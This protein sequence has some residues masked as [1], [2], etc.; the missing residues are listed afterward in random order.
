MIHE[1]NQEYDPEDE[2]EGQGEDEGEID[3]Y[4]GQV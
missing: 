2:E 4:E 3:V 1:E